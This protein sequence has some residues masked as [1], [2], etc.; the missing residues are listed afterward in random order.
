MFAPI[1]AQYLYSMLQG[2]GTLTTL[3]VIC[4]LTI[5]CINNLVD[6]LVLYEQMPV[7]V[8]NVSIHPSPV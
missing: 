4:I 2:H 5:V 7:L 8:Q 6:I 3:I 1:N